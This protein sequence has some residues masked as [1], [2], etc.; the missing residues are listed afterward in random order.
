MAELARMSGVPYD[1]MKRWGTKT[2]APSALSVYKV[3]KALG[4]TPEELLKGEI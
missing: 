3:S 2:K 1:T 4:T